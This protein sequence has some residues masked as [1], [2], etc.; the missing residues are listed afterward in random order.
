MRGIYR[1]MN[2]ERRL[3]AEIP[4]N[5]REYDAVVVGGGTAGAIAALALSMEECRVLVV[6]RLNCLGGMGTAGRIENYYFGC[7]GGL[8]EQ[9]DA[10]A[11]GSEPLGYT[12]SYPSG[13]NC[14]LKER[15]LEEKIR[16]LGGEIAY[17]ADLTGVIMDG[18]TVLGV[19]YIQ[20]AQLHC[21]CAPVVI[22]A[23]AEGYL[24]QIAGAEYTLGR[25]LD[26]K[27]QPFGN[28]R[29][30]LVEESMTGS[31]SYT[32]CGYVSPIVPEQYSQAILSAA[33]FS[34][35][36]LDDYRI[37][38]RLL[39]ITPYI[40]MREGMLIQ[41]EERLRLQDVVNGVS[42]KGKI[43]FYA[44]SNAD[45]HGKDMAFE[46][47]P[48][49]DWMI[50]CSLWG[51]NFSM[52][53]PMGCVIPRG[54]HGLLAAGRLISV[55][56]D[57]ASCV[58]ME[59]D[60]QKCGEAVGYL[61]ALAV[62][63]R[64]DVRD[65]DYEKLEKK[66][67][68]SGC[69]TEKN[70]VGFMDSRLPARQARIKMPLS[71]EEIKAGLASDSPGMAIWQ[72]AHAWQDRSPLYAFLADENDHL[73]IHA[74]MALALA[75]K[76]AGAEI[77]LE[78]VRKQDDFVPATSRKYNMIRGAAALYLLGRIAYAPALDDILHIIQ[79][80]QQIHPASFKKDEFLADEEE[81][82]F[83]YLSQA[84]VAAEEI[85]LL[86]PAAREKT[87]AVI[88]GVIDDPAFSI[89]STLKG[90]QQLKYQMADMIRH[91]VD[92]LEKKRK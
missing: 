54:I 90:R 21:A 28:V 23:T 63:D 70:H 53:V 83:Q 22:D 1:L 41:G 69:L 25:D 82:R 43:L 72:A 4:Q 39:G 26:Q 50:A 80:W 27:V 40:G 56:H 61:A 11:K 81:Y 87:D 31:H 17:G 24:C 37:G 3:A 78:C 15:V 19:E 29:I 48:Q 44:Y 89:H 18:N 34:T 85:A 66:L 76:D 64:V 13:Y 9:I 74:A 5:A 57:L 59:R 65:V 33:R 84:I 35:Y 30:D 14:E 8:Y 32:D 16:G 91:A 10:E 75:G 62:K 49:Q 58:R 47:H 88:H 79:D 92:C 12:V 71:P 46:N 6:E 42:P 2:D 7:R 20:G 36:L 45:N 52:G 67:R 77:L 73:R 86:H 38:R 68:T 60:A 55:D 51:L